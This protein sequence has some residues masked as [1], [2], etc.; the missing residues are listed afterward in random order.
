[1]GIILTQ[2]ID[3]DFNWENIVHVDH[4][5]GTPTE[6]LSILNKGVCVNH[7]SLF[8]KEFYCNYCLATWLLERVMFYFDFLSLNIITRLK[9]QCAGD[10]P[11][12]KMETRCMTHLEIPREKVTLG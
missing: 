12:I 10:L 1:M 9:I 6:I 4:V 11:R 3:T 2:T 5:Q 7:G 8:P